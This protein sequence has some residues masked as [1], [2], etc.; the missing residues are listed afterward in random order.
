MVVSVHL[1]QIWATLN[2][3]RSEAAIGG[4]EFSAVHL[5]E[6]KQHL[7]NQGIEIPPDLTADL[8]TMAWIQNNIERGQYRVNDLSKVQSKPAFD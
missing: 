4:N 1:H 8:N 7:K 2:K 6:S 5:L 3:R